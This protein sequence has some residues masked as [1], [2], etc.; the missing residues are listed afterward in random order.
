MLFLLTA[1][2]FRASD[3]QFET[4]NNVFRAQFSW[5]SAL[6]V[7]HWS[8]VLSKHSLPL[9]LVV[10][11]IQFPLHT[12]TSV[13]GCLICAPCLYAWG[14]TGSVLWLTVG[15]CALGSQLGISHFKGM[16]LYRVAHHHDLPVFLQGCVAP[17]HAPMRNSN[18]EGTHSIAPCPLYT[19]YFQVNLLNYDIP[20]FI[21]C[22]D[23]HVQHLSIRSVALCNVVS[24]YH[25]D[26]NEPMPVT[27]NMG[28]V[29]QKFWSC[30][31]VVLWFMSNCTNQLMH[32][33]ICWGRSYLGVL[34]ELYHSPNQTTLQVPE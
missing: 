15:I 21:M 5:N 3:Y 30:K 18:I 8:N 6:V 28:N 19:F 22:R 4:T 33:S 17:F 27:L 31:W 16:T 24:V 2:S 25:W 26:M 32:W 34:F 9:C 14:F 10:L 13:S 29:S 7:L 20:L 1:A 23:R 12:I 11:L